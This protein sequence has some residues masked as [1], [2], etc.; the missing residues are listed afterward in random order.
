MAGDAIRDPKIGGQSAAEAALKSEIFQ[1]EKRPCT[2]C[3]TV[4]GFVRFCALVNYQFE[5]S[6]Q[7][8]GTRRHCH[9]GTR[10]GRLMAALVSKEGYRRAFVDS[11][12]VLILRL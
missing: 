3:L 6:L 12:T 7:V 2:D 8:T 1:Q 11:R 9:I 4:A 5:V 10:I